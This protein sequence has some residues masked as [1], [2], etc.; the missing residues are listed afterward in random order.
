MDLIIRQAAECGV[1]IVAPFESE[2]S[3]VHLKKDATLKIGRWE[4]IIREARQQSGSSTETAIRSPCKFDSLLE[5]WASLKEKYQKPLGIL[6]HQEP[7]EKGTLH[8]YLGNYPDLIALAVGPEGGF[9][10]GEVSRFI[11]AGFK[12]LLMGNTILRTETA[13]LYGIAAIRTILMENE[14][15]KALLKE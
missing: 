6:L 8:D 10:S 7:L 2:Y 5:F 12:P 13:S 15:W 1:F 4:R 3:T 14:R 9:S 11:K